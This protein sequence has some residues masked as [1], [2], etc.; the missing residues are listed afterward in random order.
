MRFKIKDLEYADAYSKTFEKEVGLNNLNL[1]K[2]YLTL[3]LKPNISNEEFY[4]LVMKTCDVIYDGSFDKEYIEF[5]KNKEYETRKVPT[6][7]IRAVNKNINGYKL[8]KTEYYQE[9]V[10]LLVPKD[11]K[12]NNN[13]AINVDKFQK[14]MESG[15]VY[16]LDSYDEKIDCSIIIDELIDEIWPLTKEK[17]VDFIYK[18]PNIK[19]FGPDNIKEKLDLLPSIVKNILKDPAL[20]KELFSN[21]WESIDIIIMNEEEKK[22]N[23]MRQY[24]DYYPINNSKNNRVNFPLNYREID[25][26]VSGNIDN[27]DIRTFNYL[28]DK[29]K[30][31]IYRIPLV[32]LLESEIFAQNESI[33]YFLDDTGATLS[34]FFN[35]EKEKEEYI[36][37]L[38]TVKHLARRKY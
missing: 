10:I 35:S 18:N 15:D 9:Y 1:L 19:Q 5:I 14:L 13:M 22:E 12:I 3:R 4:H 38:R 29:M 24:E 7:N 11:F 6:T 30:E 17:L 25:D 2:L 34:H 16:Y 31:T 28:V 36:N 20:T 8:P 37:G 32:G 21:D 33:Q 23:L 26:F 27:I